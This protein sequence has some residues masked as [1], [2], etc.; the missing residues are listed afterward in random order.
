M[1]S[2]VDKSSLALSNYDILMEEATLEEI[3]IR[4]E[5]SSYTLAPA[6]ADLTGAE[7][8]LLDQI[9]RELRLRDAVDAV[10]R[11]ATTTS[12]STVRRL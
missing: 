4:I 3:S 6:N 7:V 8:E 11:N 12:S 1:G 10:R 2:G 5:H 9:G